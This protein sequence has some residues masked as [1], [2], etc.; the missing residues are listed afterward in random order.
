MNKLKEI[1]AAVE[2][3]NRI[4]G[5]SWGDWDDVH[6]II[7]TYQIK[8]EE[9]KYA[10]MIEAFVNEMID[11]NGEHAKAYID[12]LSALEYGVVFN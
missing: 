2:A 12:V 4:N 6:H 8:I 5:G 11:S 10:D 3:N 7:D 9:E 1:I